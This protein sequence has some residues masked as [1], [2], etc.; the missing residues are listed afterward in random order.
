MIDFKGH[1]V[2][3]EDKTIYLTPIEN[4]MLEILYNN[5]GKVTTYQD[6]ADKIYQIECNESLKGLIRKNMAM[7]RKKTREHINIRTVYGAGYIIE[8]ELK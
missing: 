7:L 2:L 5:K 6:I 4:D 1:R 3:L 8:E